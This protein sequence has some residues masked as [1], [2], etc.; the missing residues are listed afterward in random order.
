MSVKSFC[1][2]KGSSDMKSEAREADNSDSGSSAG[3]EEVDTSTFV[4]RE[5]PH[6]E[7]S[8]ECKGSSQW[9]NIWN[10]GLINGEVHYFCGVLGG[11]IKPDILSDLLTSCAT[12]LPSLLV[13][14]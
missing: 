13:A 2:S 10:F 7:T 12:D 3:S 5:V 1:S 4:L 11:S 8:T 14:T 9:K 6:T